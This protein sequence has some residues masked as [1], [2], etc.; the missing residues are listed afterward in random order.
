MNDCAHQGMCATK[1]K[2]E[3]EVYTLF[4]TLSYYLGFLKHI[5][6][7][8]FHSHEDSLLNSPIRHWSSSVFPILPIKVHLVILIF[9][10]LLNL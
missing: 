10:T 4:K 5:K 6:I 8:R 3:R 9:L 7:S 1:R 2:K